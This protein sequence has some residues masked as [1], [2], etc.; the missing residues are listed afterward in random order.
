MIHQPIFVNIS[1]PCLNTSQSP[2]HIQNHLKKSLFSNSSSGLLIAEDANVVIVEGSAGESFIVV[3][4]NSPTKSMV[5]SGSP[6]SIN[7]LK[8]SHLVLEE[9]N[10][11]SGSGGGVA[12]VESSTAI[13][14]TVNIPQKIIIPVGA[15][16]DT[17]LAL[18]PP[19]SSSKTTPSPS[20]PSNTITTNNSGVD[21]PTIRRPLSSSSS[22][23]TAKSLPVKT[24]V[25]TNRTGTGTA[26]ARTTA[27]K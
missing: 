7:S 14:H 9:C 21:S 26:T 4:S 20:H 6:A 10:P 17:T 19:P 13:L 15:S 12:N 23:S 18:A 2:I 25:V 27:A 22:S 1:P 3:S 24:L 8:R 16:G 11:G 5:R